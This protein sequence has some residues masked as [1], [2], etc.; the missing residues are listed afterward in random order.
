MQNGLL[1]RGWSLT[2][3]YG[4]SR[5]YGLLLLLSLPLEAF[6]WLFNRSGVV[7]FIA[8]RPQV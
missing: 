7:D 5:I 2:L 8:Q 1:A 4:R 6:A 3:E